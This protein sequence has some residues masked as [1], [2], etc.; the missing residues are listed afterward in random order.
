MTQ[1]AFYIGLFLITSCTLMLQVIQT[2]ILSV[3][4]WYHLAFFSISMA[5]FG[6][7]A[8]AVWV[9]VRRDR[10][11]E[12]TLSFDLSYYSAAFAVTT[13][14]CFMIQMTLAPVVWYSIN[15]IWTWIELALCLALPFVCSGIVVS[16]ALTR[17]PFPLGRVYG[18]DLAGA[19]V[20]CLGVLFV[21]DQIDAPSAVLWVSVVAALGA[22]CFRSSGMGTAPQILPPFYA[23]FRH[24]TV[25]FSVLFLCAVFNGLTEYGFQPL[26]I[27]GRFEGPQDPIFL[28]W[29]SLSRVAVYPM[30]ETTPYLWGPSPTLPH[31][32]YA[33]EQRRLYIDGD[34]GTV[35]T[36]FTGDLDEVRYLQYDITNLAYHLPDRS[37]TAIIGIG[38]GREILSAAVFGY[39]QIVGIETNPIFIDLLT[40]EP[41]FS[42]FTNITKLNGVTLIMSEARSW[43][44]QTEQTFDVIQLTLN[45]TWTATNAGALSLSENGLYT[46]EAWK[47]FMN[48]LRPQ[49]ALSVSRWYDPKTP[50]E[51]A[52]LLSLAS[53]TLLDMGVKEPFR[54]IFMA[55]SENIATLIVAREPFSFHDLTALN[56][57]IL[58]YQYGMFVHPSSESS[59]RIFESIVTAH[60][61]KELEELTSRQEFDLTPATDDRP[62]FFNQLP[63][64]NPFETFSLARRLLDEKNKDHGIRYGNLVATATLIFLFIVSLILV[65]L[66]IVMPLRGA[67]TNTGRK[68][69]MNGT[70][71]FL[72]IGIGF[73][74]VEISLLQRLSIFLG[75]T[76][77]LSVVLFT[78]ILFNG[79]GS[80]FS[81]SITLDRSWKFATWSL[82]TGGYLMALPMWLPD[83][84]LMFGNHS[85]SHRAMLSIIVIAP[86]G[87]LMG[88]GFPTGMRAIASIDRTP[89]AWFWGI[90]GA[91]GVLAS[92]VAVS[93]SIAFGIST[94][95]TIGALC[96]VLLFPIILSSVRAPDLKRAY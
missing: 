9:Y 92:V 64:R 13:A 71:Y 14:L 76:V 11:T 36:R 58:R 10:F 74:V 12:N 24:R 7:T 28:K 52:R 79:I 68:F 27:K 53:A 50:D 82:L 25:I 61:R 63:L 84:L 30:G 89:T 17:S 19:A 48:R 4:T 86:A 44:L 21:L 96:Y 22:L 93:T 34:A 49:G 15:S 23:I 88:F 51:A 32:K 26:V 72:L 39:R 31:A 87:L 40:Q 80:L 70:L 42:D 90:S 77:S 95:L 81:D 18:V 43:F 54:H 20:G 73:M 33:V 38:G 41:N 47:I 65:L 56:Q 46:V 6:L 78:L 85:L 67:L 66:T 5:M 94:T 57:T 60:D 29:N 59:F 83:V 62:F 37:R 75:Q 8:G 55:K 3:V 91:A 1:I 69:V 2:R 16:L 35:A 45:D